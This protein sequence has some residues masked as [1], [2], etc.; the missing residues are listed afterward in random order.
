M[1]I[2]YEPMFHAV[3]CYEP[4]AEA[5]I[6]TGIFTLERDAEQHRAQREAMPRHRNTTCIQRLTMDQITTLLVKDRLREMAGAIDRL[7]GAGAAASTA[8][9]HGRAD[10]SEALKRDLRREQTRCLQILKDVRETEGAAGV[11]ALMLCDSLD[12]AYRASEE[13]DPDAI[14]AAIDD[15][16]K[17][18][19]KAA[20]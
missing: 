9:N 18:G 8:A 12:R 13:N 2:P 10:G 19:E 14:T 1:N 20:P 4:A 5:F 11:L 17:Y 7:I 15:L 6:I 16:R 3:F